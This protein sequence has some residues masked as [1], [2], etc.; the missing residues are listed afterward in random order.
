MAIIPHNPSTEELDSVN[1]MLAAVSQAPVNQLEATNPDVAIAYDTLIRTSREVQAEGW[2]F[3]KE[4]HVKQTRTNVTVGTETQ[5]RIAIGS[6]VIQLD[7]SNNHNNAAHDGVV[8]FDSAGSPAGLYLYDRQEHTFNFD[9]DPDCDII[10]LY[11]F[12]DLPQPIRDYIVARASTIFAQ[13]LVGDRE[14][15]QILKVVE[16]ERKATALEYECNQG[17]Y[18]FFGHPEGGNFYNSYQPFTALTRY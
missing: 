7:L 12:K 18:T 3:N 6:D 14:L 5:T 1:E 10:K 9:Y 4:F 16:Q 17:D 2:T 15:Y 11:T 13:R 8:R